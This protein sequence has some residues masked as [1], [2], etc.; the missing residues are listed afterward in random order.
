MRSE[1]YAVGRITDMLQAAPANAVGDVRM[2]YQ[3]I[4]HASARPHVP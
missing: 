2:D 3:G 4:A 1:A